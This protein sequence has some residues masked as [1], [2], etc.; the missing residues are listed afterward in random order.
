LAED[1]LA[2]EDEPGDAVLRLEAALERIAVLATSHPALPAVPVGA[3]ARLDG[4]GVDTAALAGRLDS[5]ISQ[6]RS[7]LGTQ[8][9]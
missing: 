4:P 5:L 9:I 6:L 3:A 2:E 7:A 1:G 8:D